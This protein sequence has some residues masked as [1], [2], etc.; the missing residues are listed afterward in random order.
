MKQYEEVSLAKYHTFG[1]D[2]KARKLFVADSEEDI[3]DFVDKYEDFIILGEGSNSV[4]TKD[5]TKPILQINIKGMSVLDEDENTVELMVNAGEN[6][7]ELVQIA[8]HKGWGGIENLALIPGTVGA[9]PVQNIGAYGVEVSKSIVSVRGIN[10]KTK[11]VETLLS[12][13][14]HFSYRNSVFKNSLKDQ[15]VITAVTFRLTKKNHHF[16]TSYHPLEEALQ[17]KNQEAT[18]TSIF[19]SVIEIRNSKLPDPTKIGNSGSFFKNPIISSEF[20]ADLQ[21]RFPDMPFYKQ[22]EQAYKIPAAWLIENS[23]WKGKIYK[24]VGVY[25]KHALVLINVGNGK[26]EDLLRLIDSIQKSVE[27]K[28]DLPLIPEV[29]IY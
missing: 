1:L 23:G 10:R 16:E 27:E 21:S 17:L 25:P 14:C 2:Q 19:D 29:N 22:N 13:E 24:G 3:V 9:A 11:K 4:F 26:G 6:W 8:V 20:F 28:Y 15:F 7:H 5:I 18:L 12:Q